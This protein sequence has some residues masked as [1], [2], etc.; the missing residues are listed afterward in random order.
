MKPTWNKL[1]LCK[2]GEDT[3]SAVRAM[4][5]PGQKLQDNK[6]VRVL[7]VFSGIKRK[8]SM[9]SFMKAIASK[10]SLNLEVHEW[11]I[12]NGQEYDLADDSKWNALLSRIR[13]HDFSAVYWSPPCSTFSHCRSDYDMGP[14]PLRGGEG[15]ERYGRTDVKLTESEKESLKLGTLMALRTAEGISVCNELRI[16]WLLENPP[17]RPG[18]PSLFGLDEII[19]VCKGD[20]QKYVCVPAVYVRSLT[21]EMDGDSWYDRIT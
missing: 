21:W 1:L 14:R 10:I 19:E 3:R 9:A 15:K 12:E 17:Q 16:G 7:Y 13:A 11:D 6:A 18:K 5:S 20:V 8:E 2:T 4:N